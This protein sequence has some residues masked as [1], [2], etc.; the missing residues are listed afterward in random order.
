MV[1]ESN[2]STKKI[3]EKISQIAA[4]DVLTEREEDKPG[5]S[6]LAG[7]KG[8]TSV[9]D[10]LCSTDVHDNNVEQKLKAYRAGVEI[11]SVAMFSD[12]LDT[13]GSGLTAGFML[14]KINTLE[15]AIN[16]FKNRKYTTEPGGLPSQNTGTSGTGMFNFVQDL[17]KKGEMSFGKKSGTMEEPKIDKLRAINE[18]AKEELIKL[19]EEGK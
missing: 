3:A 9:Y 15:E 19:K 10:K 7:L 17:A 18:S 14:S 4:M 13:T 1:A 8:D 5:L 2:M 16:L 12:A 11:R 6:F